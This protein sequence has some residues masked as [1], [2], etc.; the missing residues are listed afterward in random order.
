[1]LFEIPGLSRP[2]FSYLVWLH[3]GA[4]HWR[5]SFWSIY[6]TNNIAWLCIL[7]FFGTAGAYWSRRA[8]SGPAM[9]A[10][11]G[12]SPLALFLAMFAVMVHYSFVLDGVS[13]TKELAPA[14][15]VNALRWAVFPGLA[16]FLGV[17]PFLCRD[18][19]RGCDI[20]SSI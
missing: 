8:G 13:P 15:A 12:L 10:A 5:L 16:L 19:Y 20:A 7:P 2:G 17:F 9:Q 1:M 11:A 6:G 18:S 14:L 4:L 3:E